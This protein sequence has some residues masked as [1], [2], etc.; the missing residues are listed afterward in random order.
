MTNK[1]FVTKLKR[2]DKVK[3]APVEEMMKSPVYVHSL[4]MWA[5]Q[6]VTIDSMYSDYAFDI[7]EDDTGVPKWIFSADMIERKVTDARVEI[8]L[9]PWDEAIKNYFDAIVDKYVDNY[10]VDNYVDNR[11]LGITEKTWKQLQEGKRYYISKE[12]EGRGLIDTV[13]ICSL[14]FDWII[15]KCCVRYKDSEYDKT[16]GCLT[17]QKPSDT[18]IDKLAEGIFGKPLIETAKDRVK[19]ELAELEEKVEKLSHALAPLADKIGTDT[20]AYSLLNLQL[21]V[22]KTYANILLRRLAIWKD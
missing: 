6:I 21:E 14:G 19:K 1:E 20:E 5:E 8:E 7:M 13:R 11:I 9:L 22:M 16:Q 3:L 12:D 15:P 18:A 17:K 2:G 4:D 10:Y